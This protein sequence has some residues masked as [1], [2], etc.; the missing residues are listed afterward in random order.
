[1]P[2]RILMFTI[3]LR[4][5]FPVYFALGPR[6][7]QFTHMDKPH[8][9]LAFQQP[10][11]DEWKE[12]P[13]GTQ[14]TNETENASTHAVSEMISFNIFPVSRCPPRLHITDRPLHI[15]RFWA[16]ARL[17]ASPIEDDQRWRAFDREGHGLTCFPP[18]PLGS[19]PFSGAYY[20]PVLCAWPLTLRPLAPTCLFL[21]QLPELSEL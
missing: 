3:S 2:P 1:M 18:L 7:C 15:S 20:T 5:Y 12:K 16:R 9:Y 6:V 13:L 21:K 19:L 11:L 8:F 4:K 14:N 17:Q 10:C